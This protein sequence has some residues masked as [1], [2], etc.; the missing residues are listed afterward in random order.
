MYPNQSGRVLDKE[1]DIVTENNAGRTGTT[2]PGGLH[3]NLVKQ[4]SLMGNRTPSKQQPQGLKMNPAGSKT[5]MQ[6][7][8]SNLGL[9]SPSAQS[10]LRPKTNYQLPPTAPVADDNNT[11]NLNQKKSGLARTFSTV[12][13]SNNNNNNNNSDS[14]KAPSTPIKS[15]SSRRLSLTKRGSAKARLVVLKDEPA[16]EDIA[17]APVKI[18]L[19]AGQNI[20]TTDGGSGGGGGAKTS[21]RPVTR[22]AEAAPLES[23]TTILSIGRSLESEDKVVVGQAKAETKRRAL[24]NEDDKLEIEYCPPPIEERPYEPDF[25]VINYDVLKTDP[26]SLAYQ[27]QYFDY[28][29]PPLPDFELLPTQRPSRA[30]SSSSELSDT[31]LYIP[32]AK[33]TLTA[34]GHLDVTW[35]DD[36]DDEENDGSPHPLGGISHGHTGPISSGRLFGIKDL[37]NEDKLRAPFDGFMFD[38]SEDSLSEDEDDI[39]GSTRVGATSSSSSNRTGS[40]SNKDQVKGVAVEEADEFN[41]SFGLDDLEDESKVKAPFSDFFF[42]L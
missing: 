38:L 10:V 25:E 11:A 34:D 29:E 3:A 17:Q 42:D 39:F 8:V 16:P 7:K 24:T 26:P 37:P 2:G 28:S 35:S 19:G 13:E 5:P 32:V 9:N 27:Y 4:N 23:A 12:L 15:D 20:K 30:F 41:K 22:L 31:E 1:N 36:D 6:G 14:T 40:K 33:T 21:R 18:N